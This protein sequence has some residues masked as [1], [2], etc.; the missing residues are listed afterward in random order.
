M[1]KLS[2]NIAEF[3]DEAGKK[4]PLAKIAQR[5]AHVRSMWA[6]CV[7]GVVL[8]HTNSIYI[9]KEGETKQ[10]IVYVD[11]SITAAEL[12][13]R[14]EL[15]KMKFLQK[16]QEDIDEFKILI[17]RG[18]YKKNYPFK[19]NKA[20]T[21]KDTARSVPLDE[22]EKQHVLELVSLIENPKLRKS[23]FEAMV[24]DLEWK[25]GSESLG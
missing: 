4:D 12:N 9:I 3:Y 8:Q 10:L 25:K 24:A 22:E 17:S 14:R 15:I 19:E 13:A 5:A 6:A 20:P 18:N 7:E 1:K 21:T 11:D 2:K 16:F 23:V